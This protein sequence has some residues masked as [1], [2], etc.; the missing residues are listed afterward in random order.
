MWL[1][2]LVGTDRL[3]TGRSG[4][5]KRNRRVSFEVVFTRGHKHEQSVPAGLD[6]RKQTD[7]MFMED[8]GGRN[9]KISAPPGT[10]GSM[11]TVEATC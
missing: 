6:G 7:M 2:L 8:V 3:R 1:N 9:T 11:T 4:G 10:S 5:L